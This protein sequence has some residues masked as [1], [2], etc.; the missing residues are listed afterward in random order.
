MSDLADF[1]SYYLAAS[2]DQ[3]LLWA[4]D[5]ANLLPTARSALSEELERR[6]L[7]PF[8][9]EAPPE[10]QSP[11]F[12]GWLLVYCFSA[13]VIYP[14]WLVFNCIDR[15]SFALICAPHS[16]LVIG[17]GILLWK[18][19]PRGL[20][21]IR[22][23]YLYLLTLFC[24]DLIALI[25]SGNFE[26]LGTFIGSVLVGSIPLLLWWRYFRRSTYV[27]AIYGQNMRRLFGRKASG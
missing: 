20:D 9:V 4:S 11:K 8:V 26:A 10:V 2:D 6:H 16:V 13:L 22:W 19:N 14:I 1:R 18:R 23:A 25:F 12:G 21:W 24:L 17:S 5:A 27:R 15:P 3:L 7:P